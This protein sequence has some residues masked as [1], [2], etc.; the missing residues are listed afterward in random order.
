M[1][2]FK[3]E[4]YTM[5]ISD[6]AKLLKPFKLIWD[7]DKSKDKDLALLELSYV[8]F[9]EDV[10]SDYKMYQDENERSNKIIED[11]GYPKK[12]KPDKLV[13]DARVFYSSF[14]TDAQLLLEDMRG[15]VAKLR[16]HMLE[17]LDLSLVDDKGKP[18]YTLDSYTKTVSDL[19]KLVKNIHT[20]ES[21]IIKDVDNE[22]KVRGQA[23]KSM[24]E[25]EDDE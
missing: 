24:L 21:D 18:I 9:M 3:Y 12:W 10:R 23:T 5:T 17:N 20:I 19:G 22:D 11:N 25:D 4:G 15:M 13:Q 2:L 6:E 7:R 8:Y 14:K 16:K 1:K